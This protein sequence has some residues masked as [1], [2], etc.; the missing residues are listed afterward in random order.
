MDYGTTHTVDDQTA[1]VVTMP[2]QT[3]RT[4]QYRFRRRDGYWV[5]SRPRDW[6]TEHVLRYAERELYGTVLRRH[7]PPSQSSL[8]DFAPR[9][10]DGESVSAMRTC[11]GG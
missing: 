3:K 6:Y 10:A 2:K 8:A 9:D 5:L 4:F 7:L 11:T 1:L